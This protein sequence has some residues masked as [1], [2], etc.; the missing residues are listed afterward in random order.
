VG[1]EGPVDFADGMSL[2]QYVRSSPTGVV[3]PHGLG[4]INRALI[5][6]GLKD[7]DLNETGT[8]VYHEA[9]G[10]VTPD[11]VY[12]GRRERLL[13]RRR[14]QTGESHPYRGT[15]ENRLP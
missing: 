14:S 8:G 1:E 5:W 15:Q 2:F 12:F 10:N 7:K 6:L 4:W 9:L 3:D 11:D 13:S